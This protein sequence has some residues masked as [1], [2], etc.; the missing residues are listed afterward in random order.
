MIEILTIQYFI[1]VSFFIQLFVFFLGL[2]VKRH[3]FA[4]FFVIFS[5]LIYPQTLQM[6]HLQYGQT[7]KSTK[8]LLFFN[9]SSS[10]C[11]VLLLQ[12]KLVLVRPI[13]SYHG[14]TSFCS[15]PGNSILSSMFP[16]CKHFSFP[17]IP[18]FSRVHC[19]VA[20]WGTQEKEE[21]M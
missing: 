7:Y 3:L 14:G 17:Y 18:F 11:P 2:V 12:C 10:W 21:D 8:I 1:I 9:Y 16:R 13:Q 20:F 4:F 19:P 5:S 15:H 6:N